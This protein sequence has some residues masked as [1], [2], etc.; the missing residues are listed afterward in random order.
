[1]RPNAIF[2]TLA[3]AG[4][5]AAPLAAQQTPPPPPPAAPAAP[6]SRMRNPASPM[7]P[8]MAGMQGGMAGMMAGMM[9]GMQGG[10]MA[11]H[12]PQDLLALRE[13]LALTDAQ[14]QQIMSIAAQARAAARPHFEAAMRAHH[15]AMQALETGDSPDLARF[16]AQLKEAANHAVEAQLTLA[17]AGSQ[18]LA[19]LTP[20]QRANVRFAMRLQHA[21]MMQGMMGGMGKMSGMEGG[22]DSMQGMKHEMPGMKHDSMPGMKHEMPGMKHEMAP[23]RK[24]STTKH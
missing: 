12:G 15:D 21:R 19:L 6:G 5:A 2:L 9:G 8:K 17:R 24:D 18:A 4:V 10:M 13:A 20:E 7:P 1:M 23:A 22:M 3:M 11:Q 16:E 14:V